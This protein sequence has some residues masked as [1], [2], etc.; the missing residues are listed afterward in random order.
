MGFEVH[1][2]TETYY[3]LF[4]GKPYLQVRSLKI[5]DWKIELFTCPKTKMRLEHPHFS[6]SEI[7]DFLILISQ[8]FRPC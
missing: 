1:V 3:L 6:H 7:H 5:N 8:F 4:P 2:F